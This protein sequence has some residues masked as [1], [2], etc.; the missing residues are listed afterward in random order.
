VYK[1]LNLPANICITS[2]KCRVPSI[3]SVSQS[4]SAHTTS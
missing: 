1:D 4:L 3:V 2:S